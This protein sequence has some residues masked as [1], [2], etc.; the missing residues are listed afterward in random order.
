MKYLANVFP[1]GNRR[2]VVDFVAATI[3]LRAIGVVSFDASRR[4]RRK[5]R[6]PLAASAV[7][8]WTVGPGVTS[9][10]VFPLKIADVDHSKMQVGTP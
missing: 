4:R 2:L 3:D 6:S 10:R 7:A 9:W 1:F 8:A 5:R